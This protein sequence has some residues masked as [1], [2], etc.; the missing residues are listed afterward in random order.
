MSVHPDQIRWYAQSALS[1]FETFRGDDAVENAKAD[2]RSL[3]DYLDRADDTV[4]ILPI[5]AIEPRINNE[6]LIGDAQGMNE[7][8][9]KIVRLFPLL[10]LC[11]V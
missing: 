8:Y 4:R 3:L 1:G 5:E 9:L 7:P 2:L 10:R 11:R 6:G